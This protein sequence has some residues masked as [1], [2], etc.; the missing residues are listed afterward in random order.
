MTSYQQRCTTITLLLQLLLLITTTS[1][2][3]LTKAECSSYSS[4]FSFGDSLA[5][6]G[7]LY[8]SSHQPSDHCFFPPYGETYFHHPSN[9]C[10]DGRLMIDFIAEWLGIPMLKPYLGIKNGELE[11]LNVNEGVNFAVIGATALEDSFFEER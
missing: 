4:I 9:R 11:D 3:L 8:F 7:N 10:S 5:D 1:P 2:P 6:T